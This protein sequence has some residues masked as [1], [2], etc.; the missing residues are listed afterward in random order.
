[1]RFKGR[2][3]FFGLGVIFFSLSSSRLLSI[4]GWYNASANNP[5]A[6]R[7]GAANG[8]P[9]ATLCPLTLQLQ[10]RQSRRH[11]HFLPKNI[12]FCSLVSV[13]TAEQR[14]D[15]VPQANL[16]KQ[17]C[18]GEMTATTAHG[19]P[20]RTGYCAFT[21]QQILPVAKCGIVLKTSHG[22]KTNKQKNLLTGHIQPEA[23]LNQTK[24]Y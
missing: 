6:T 14:G 2:F 17:H 7:E 9:A 15:C 3:Y 10:C 5:A 19:S 4:V 12:I 8:P 21:L 23:Q 11:V 24:Y 18:L 20:I 22:A 16:W 13:E 1:M